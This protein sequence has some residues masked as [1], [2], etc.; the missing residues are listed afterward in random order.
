MEKRHECIQMFD[1]FPRYAAP[2]IA[3]L[4]VGELSRSAH[5]NGSNGTNLDVLRHVGV[6]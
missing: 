4:A 3:S 1:L 6:N 5:S 2:G